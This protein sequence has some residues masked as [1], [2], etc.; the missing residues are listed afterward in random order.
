MTGIAELVVIG[1]VV[2]LCVRWRRLKDLGPTVRESARAF[3][4]GLKGRRPSRL[5]EPYK[6]ESKPSLRDG[7]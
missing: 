5:V 6:G 2:Y 4:E 7:I 3:S 1:C